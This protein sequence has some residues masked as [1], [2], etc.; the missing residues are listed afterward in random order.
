MRK[1]R[2]ETC[3]KAWADKAA[4]REAEA[5][6]RAGDPRMRPWDVTWKR[7]DA[8]EYAR[9]AASLGRLLDGT[10]NADDVRRLKHQVAI[11][12]DKAAA[13]GALTAERLASVGSQTRLLRRKARQAGH[14]GL[15]AA[16]LK[17]R[18]A[19]AA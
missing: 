18:L 7:G 17:G 19:E 5:R 3:R 9:L 14:L 16:D 15:L 11:W 12:E 13:A 2:L 10:G 4:A 1:S 6:R 8:I